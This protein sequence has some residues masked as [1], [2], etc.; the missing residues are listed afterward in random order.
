MFKR[1]EK[2]GSVRVDV[3]KGTQKLKYRI[4]AAKRQG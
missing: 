3:S 4:S 2:E 1:E